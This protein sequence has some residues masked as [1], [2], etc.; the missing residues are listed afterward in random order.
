MRKTFDPVRGLKWRWPFSVC[1]PALGQRGCSQSGEE[2]E[3]VAWYRAGPEQ[4][5]NVLTV[6]KNSKRKQ[7]QP[8]NHILT[9]YR[10]KNKSK[11]ALWEENYS[12]NVA[13]DRTRVNYTGA[14]S[15]NGAAAWTEDDGVAAQVFFWLTGFFALN[16]KTAYICK[17][18]VV[19]GRS[20][21]D[22]KATE[23]EKKSAEK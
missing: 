7:Q 10:R 4:F 17:Q 15:Q 3:E 16:F 13:A 14:K 20:G 11:F 2:V 23:K 1:Q 5:L 9:S 21:A 8:N 22:L 19:T 12:A 6:I 18:K